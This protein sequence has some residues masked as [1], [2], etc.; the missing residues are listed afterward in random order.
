MMR[1]DAIVTIIGNCDHV[2]SE[3]LAHGLL[4][5]VQRKSTN[6]PSVKLLLDSLETGAT[7]LRNVLKT[8][9]E[10]LESALNLLVL[11]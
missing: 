3:C 7:P 1:R 9:L 10:V 2:C 6:G 5:L 4:R 11:M 8:N